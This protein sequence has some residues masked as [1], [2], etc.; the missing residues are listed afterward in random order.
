MKIKSNPTFEF[1]ESSTH[2]ESTT[3]PYDLHH[4]I[5]IPFSRLAYLR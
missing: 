1:S 4:G 5:R 2:R 3:A